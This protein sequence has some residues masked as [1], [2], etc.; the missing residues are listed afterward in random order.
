MNPITFPIPVRAGTALEAGAVTSLYHALQA[1]PDPR[2]GQGKRYS[3]AL[4]L[5]LVIASQMSGRADDEWSDGLGSPSSQG[6][7]AAVWGAPTDDAVPDDL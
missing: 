4:L 5:S 1:L 6:T 2:R 3:L 7:G